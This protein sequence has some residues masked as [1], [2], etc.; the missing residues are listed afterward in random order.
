MQSIRQFLTRLGT[1]AAHPTAFVVVA[2]YATCWY[3]FS[4]ESLDWHA[5]TTLAVWCMTLLI[6]RAEQRDTLAIHAKLDELLAA[7]K[8]ARTELSRVDEKE[9][10]EIAELRDR[11]R[12]S[13]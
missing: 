13:G 9:P 11:G 7:D 6:Q 10:E 3:F 8:R 12:Q 4:P 2:V 5:V 1:L